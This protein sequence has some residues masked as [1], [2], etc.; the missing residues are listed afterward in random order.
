MWG[1]VVAAIMLAPTPPPFTTPDSDGGLSLSVPSVSCAAGRC[2][3]AFRAVN[4][5]DGSPLFD[6]ADQIAYDPTGR[7]FR[8]D[9]A[10]TASANGGHPVTRRFHHGEVAGGVLV[11][12]LPPGDRVDRVVLHGHAGTPGRAFSSSPPR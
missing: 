5:S 11:F 8:V 9:A 7:A 12:T 2:E 3:V 6:E 1:F 4:V 10:A